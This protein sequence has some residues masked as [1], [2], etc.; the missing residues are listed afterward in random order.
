MVREWK[1]N[2][3]NIYVGASGGLGLV[4]AWEF[5]ARLEITGWDPFQVS[6]PLS[7]LRFCKGTRV[8]FRQTRARS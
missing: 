8:L 3:E 4:R 5:W 1:E 2:C 6:A 7:R